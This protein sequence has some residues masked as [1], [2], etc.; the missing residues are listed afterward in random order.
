MAR[1]WWRIGL[2][3]EQIKSLEAEARA[4]RANGDGPAVRRAVLSRARSFGKRHQP[5]AIRL[6]RLAACIADQMKENTRAPAL[7]NAEDAPRGAAFAGEEL[8][9]KLE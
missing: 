3:A 1:R 5:E 2:S 7:N 6:S 8:A 4:L 9:P